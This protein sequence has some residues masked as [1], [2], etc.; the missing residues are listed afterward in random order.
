[1]SITRTLTLDL[2]ESK[3]EREWLSS[4]VYDTLVD[5]VNLPETQ[6]ISTY[7]YTV[8]VTYTVENI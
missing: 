7:E 5:E 2:N 6:E 4:L 1:M 3:I 8:T